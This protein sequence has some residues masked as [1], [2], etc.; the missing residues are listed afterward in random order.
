MATIDV[1]DAAGVTQTVGKYVPGRTAAADS[2]PVV[3]STE[4]KAA[5]DAITARLPS[6]AIFTPGTPKTASTPVGMSVSTSATGT[7]WVAFGSQACSSLDLINTAVLSASPSAIAAATNLR[8]RYVGQTPWFTLREGA[9]QL[10]L[11][12]TNANQ[13]EIQRADGSNTQIPLAA[14]AY[15]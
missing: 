3:L 14:I 15:P 13:V 9:S 4:D 1:K 2:G 5:V 7:A 11:G 12:I 10:V 6:N 8:W